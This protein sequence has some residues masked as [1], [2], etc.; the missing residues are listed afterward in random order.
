[1]NS[2]IMNAIPVIAIINNDMT[3]LVNP[4]RVPAP[5]MTL[6]IAKATTQQISIIV[7]SLRF[8]KSVHIRG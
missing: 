2:E 7:A 3:P 6:T 5:D 8:P 1:M 4:I